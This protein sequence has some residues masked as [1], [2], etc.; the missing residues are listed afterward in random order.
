MI[1]LVVVKY[2]SVKLTALLEDAASA[3]RRADCSFD[4]MTICP[5]KKPSERIDMIG[6]RIFAIFQGDP[7]TN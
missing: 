7:V 1:Y 5:E 4:A 3:G 2:I 6:D